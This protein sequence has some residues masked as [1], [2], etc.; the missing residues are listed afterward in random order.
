MGRGRVATVA[1]G[2]ARAGEARDAQSGCHVRGRGGREHSPRPARTLQTKV[3]RRHRVLEAIAIA[4]AREAC[5]RRD[6]SEQAMAQSEARGREAGC[7]R[8]WWCPSA[9]QDAR[10]RRRQW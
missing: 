8:D 9:R 2:N 10:C 1:N 3:P 7:R 4:F 5:A 6:G